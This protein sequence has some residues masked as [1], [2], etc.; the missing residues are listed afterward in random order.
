MRAHNQL[1]IA[2]AAPDQTDWSDGNS[3]SATLSSATHRASVG[4]HCHAAV[5]HAPGFGWSA[6]TR[7][8]LPRTGLRLT[9]IDT[10]H[11]GKNLRQN[12]KRARAKGLR[13]KFLGLKRNPMH[14]GDSKLADYDQALNPAIC[15]EFLLTEEP[16]QNRPTTGE[17]HNQL[18]VALQNASNDQGNSLPCICDHLKET[19]DRP[20]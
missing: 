19:Q 13:I 8:R 9:C 12:A 16:S 5:C 15:I 18:C 2:L 4:L 14:G 11:Q 17:T 7:C 20:R 1:T 10:L 6:L 3:R